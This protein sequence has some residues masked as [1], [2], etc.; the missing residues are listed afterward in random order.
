MRNL[1]SIEVSRLL[2]VSCD[3]LF[4]SICRLKL[5]LRVVSEPSNFKMLS[6]QVCK[7]VAKPFFLGSTR[8][9]LANKVFRS[10]KLAV[11]AVSLALSTSNEPSPCGCKPTCARRVKLPTAVPVPPMI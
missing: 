6:P 2:N 8:S 10:V 4:E 3:L 1:S 11:A 7:L 5:S 9:L